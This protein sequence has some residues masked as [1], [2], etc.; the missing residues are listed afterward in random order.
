M[1]VTGSESTKH[2]RAI[3]LG[4]EMLTKEFEEWTDGRA[5]YEQDFL[6]LQFIR[7]AN[8]VLQCRTMTVGTPGE[9]RA[10]GWVS[11]ITPHTTESRAQCEKHREELQQLVT[12]VRGRTFEE[13]GSDT[14]ERL[15]VLFT[16][17]IFRVLRDM[18]Q[19]TMEEWINT[20]MYVELLKVYAAARIAACGPEALEE[21]FP[22]YN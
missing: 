11:K 19:G 5:Q 8:L 10:K 2:K 9:D 12:H 3:L 17:N 6:D 20:Q 1:D 21:P 16:E 13:L 7:T 18:T 4:L 14:L 22:F 15:K